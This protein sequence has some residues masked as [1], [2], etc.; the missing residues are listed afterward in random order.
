MSTIQDVIDDALIRGGLRSISD[1]DD[2]VVVTYAFS[3]LNRMLDQWTAEVGPLFNIQDSQTDAPIPGFTLV[4][5]QAKYTLG[6]ANL[7]GIRP[8]NV[9]TIYLLDNNNVSYY[10]TVISQDDYA[11]LIYKVAPGRPTKVYINYNA[12]T[13]DL[14]FYP[15][16]SYT[17]S[18]H[19]NYLD[20]LTAFTSLAQ[21]IVYPPGYEDTFINSLAVRL[22][23]AFGKTVPP[24][25]AQAASWG[26]NVLNANN[27]DPYTLQT[28]MPTMRR[29]FFNILTGETV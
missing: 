14:Y 19:V 5:A 26:K 25:V 21:T 28:P 12:S 8:P 7:L 22:A 9:H 15:T 2:A 1:P 23:L 27:N 4:G 16:P 24:A 20:P 10:Q 17:D 6:P 11:R 3:V 18:V 29:R 13:I